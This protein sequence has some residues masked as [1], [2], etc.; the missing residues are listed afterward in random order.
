VRPVLEGQG[1]LLNLW[2]VYMM[3]SSCNSWRKRKSRIIA[4]APVM[5]L[6]RCLIEFHTCQGP[7][8]SIVSPLS[9]IPY[10]AMCRLQTPVR[11]TY[12]VSRLSPILHG[13]ICSLNGTSIRD[14]IH[15]PP[16]QPPRGPAT[17]KGEGVPRYSYIRGRKIHVDM[18]AP[19]VSSNR[20]KCWGAHNWPASSLSQGNGDLP[21]TQ[22]SKF[23]AASWPN[24]PT[25]PT[26]IQVG[27]ATVR[28]AA[29]G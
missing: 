5:E 16:N 9:P 3:S 10:G 7:H 6:H 14:C 12:I 29:F 24:S 20:R 23:Q 15:S 11:H 13:A 4:V 17:H 8:T 25:S 2:Y 21:L 22:H 19:Q 18:H 27:S 26:L 1:Q 28:M